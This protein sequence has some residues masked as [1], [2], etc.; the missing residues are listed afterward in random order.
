M[1]WMA[2][3]SDCFVIGGCLGNQSCPTSLAI[4]KAVR[5]LGGE[6][7]VIGKSVRHFLRWRFVCQS[8]AVTPEVTCSAVMPVQR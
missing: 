2:G 5:D 7:V 8:G 1:F 4:R 3:F 6:H